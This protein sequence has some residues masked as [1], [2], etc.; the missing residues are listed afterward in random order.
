[1]SLTI[2]CGKFD[3]RRMRFMQNNYSHGKP[4]T[5]GPPPDVG[6]KTTRKNRSG[7]SA[8]STRSFE[9]SALARNV[10]YKLLY[11][12]THATITGVPILILFN[13]K[14]IGTKLID[15]YNEIIAIERNIF[16]SYLKYIRLNRMKSTSRKSGRESTNKSNEEGTSA[17]TQT[18][19][20]HSYRP[21]FGDANS[22]LAALEKQSGGYFVMRINGVHHDTVTNVLSLSFRIL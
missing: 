3:G 16:S 13:S 5:L 7:S 17:N 12:T 6:T 1:M 15:I 21:N 8:S 4:E 2:P 20:T 9:T 10:Y 11:L 22:L 18:E 19:Y 14:T